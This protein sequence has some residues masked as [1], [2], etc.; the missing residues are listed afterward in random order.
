MIF[1]KW[2]KKNPFALISDYMYLR[3][4]KFSVFRALYKSISKY[5]CQP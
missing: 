2:K 4:R 5:M 1:E 3:M